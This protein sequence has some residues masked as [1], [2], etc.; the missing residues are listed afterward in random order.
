VE[1]ETHNLSNLRLRNC[2]IW[3]IYNLKPRNCGKW[4][5]AFTMKRSRSHK[6]TGYNRCIK[7]A[8]EIF[9]S[10]P[11]EISPS[12]SYIHGSCMLLNILDSFRD[13]KMFATLFLQKSFIFN[14]RLWN[15]TE[16]RT[17]NNQL[18]R[19]IFIRYLTSVFKEQQKSFRLFHILAFLARSHQ[20]KRNISKSTLCTCTVF[21]KAVYKVRII[22]SSS[23]EELI[24]KSDT[25]KA[26][27]IIKLNEN[28]TW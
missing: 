19:L 24:N 11:C 28:T 1:L 6:R 5:P 8:S 20:S 14:E 12:S 7:L 4:D 17:S 26:K 2:G 3:Y 27:I 9:I 16:N 15:L 23:K 13:F 21:F 25:S 22:L 10:T 18:L